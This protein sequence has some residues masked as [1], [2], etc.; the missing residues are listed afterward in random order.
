MKT[1][2][3]LLFAIIVLAAGNLAAKKAESSAADPGW[4]R[5]R[6]NEHGRLVYYQPQVDDW[7]D[8]KELKFRMAFSFTPKG[9]KEI[10]GILVLQAQSHVKY[11]RSQRSS[12]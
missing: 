9:A 10:I 5:L 2:L 11:G 3:S 1:T 6:I 4:P 7:K 8:F 12:Q